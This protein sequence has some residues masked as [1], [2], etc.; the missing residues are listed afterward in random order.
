MCSFIRLCLGICYLEG[1]QVTSKQN[2]T[3]WISTIHM[4]T[5]KVQDVLQKAVDCNLVTKMNLN[6]GSKASLNLL[7][8]KHIWASFFHPFCCRSITSCAPLHLISFY[9]MSF[10][11]DP[12]FP[13]IWLFL[14]EAWFLSWFPVANQLKIEDNDKINKEMNKKYVKYAEHRLNCKYYIYESYK[15][16][17]QVEH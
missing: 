1:T 13:V 10:F 14:S 12:P 2:R 16:V 9:I 5:G 4:Y 7:I 8:S 15:S 11:G 6:I 3:K 17:E